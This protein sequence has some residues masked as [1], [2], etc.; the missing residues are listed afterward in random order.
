MI[1]CGI[2]PSRG[3]LAVSIVKDREEI[4]YF[5]LLNEKKGYQKLFKRLNKLDTLSG[6]YIEGYADFAKRFALQCT[7]KGIVLYEINPLKSKKLKETI[8]WDKSDHIDAYIAALLPFINSDLIP[9][10]LTT[11]VEALK[12]L[13]RE[14]DKMGNTITAFKNRLHSYLNQNFGPVYKKLF[15]QLTKTALN[16]F[17]VFSDPETIKKANINEI[18]KALV[19]SGAKYYMGKNGIKKAKEIKKII[20]ETDPDN[21][22]IFTET[23]STIIISIA[24]ILLELIIQRNNLA[25]KIEKV[26]DRYFPEYK[27]AFQEKLKAIGTIT[28]ATL[29][30]EIG[31]IENFANDGKLAAFAGQAPRNLQSANMKKRGKRKSYDR[32][33]AKVIHMIALNNSKEK[34]PFYEYYQKKI[35][36]T[37]KRLRALKSVKRK[38]CKLVFDV[39]KD[40]EKLRKNKYD[41]A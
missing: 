26:M 7:K 19:K 21:F 31:D 24:K 11:K 36:E 12:K 18:Q 27:N 30:A 37:S 41:V 28:I 6:I 8:T 15:K 33:L 1:T 35:K 34:G 14:Y 5:K 9:L 2:D 13:T 29:I 25:K 16:F 20:T 3:D 40:I 10:S 39:F 4:D 23:T 32:F 22:D 17:I 38:V